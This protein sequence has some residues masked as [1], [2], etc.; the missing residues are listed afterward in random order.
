MDG[1]YFSGNL[2]ISGN[3]ETGRQYKITF[4]KGLPSTSGHKLTK[5]MSKTLAIPHREGNVAFSVAGRYLPPQGKLAIPVK[6][7]NITNLS[8]SAA[9]VLPQNLVYLLSRENMYDGED[10]AARGLSRKPVK[11]NLAIERSVDKSRTHAAP[12]R[13][14]RR[15][16]PRHL[17]CGG[18]GARHTLWLRE[19]R[20]APRMRKRHRH[21]RSRR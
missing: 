18:D 10:E 7:V 2:R 6:T 13:L 8:I 15:G 4:L 3:F 9:Q 12:S 5:N 16:K 20:F 1:S 17:L 19:R 14:P 11:G 21:H